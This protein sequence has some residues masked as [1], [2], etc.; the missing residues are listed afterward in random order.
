MTEKPIPLNPD[1]LADAP[2]S[3]DQRQLW[4]R[5]RFELL[6]SRARLQDVEKQG[7][8]GAVLH[9]VLARP[10]F[11]R[12]VARMLAYDER[13]GGSSSLVYID[14]EN[15]KELEEKHDRALLNAALRLIG[16]CLIKHVRGSDIVGRVGP[17][18]FAVLLCQC[19]GDLA[20]K[21]ADQLSGMARNVFDNIY[22]Q[23]LAASICYGVYAFEGEK[24]VTAGLKGAAAQLVRKQNASNP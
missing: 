2:L 22:G 16:E 12:E 14:I 8:E 1:P 23:K 6:E 13:Y 3:P 7:A 4:G 18:E 5:F 24:D 17:D 10:E 21:K 11:N 20:W 19:K 15:F 9:T